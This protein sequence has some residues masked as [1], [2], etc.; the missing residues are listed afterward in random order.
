MH[1]VGFQ[2]NIAQLQ[3]ARNEDFVRN[4]YVSLLG[5]DPRPD[6][7]SRWTGDID[8]GVR[9]FDDFNKYLMRT[10]EYDQQVNYNFKKL[11]IQ[12][13]DE[14]V[15]MDL[16]KP[17]REYGGTQPITEDTIV[18]FLR[19]TDKFID[20]Y[21]PIVTNLWKVLKDTD[22]TDVLLDYYLTNFKMDT[23][24]TVEKLQDD[25]LSNT[26]FV[27]V[28][29]M[30]CPVNDIA[31]V[32]GTGVSVDDYR[33]VLDI[34]KNAKLAAELYLVAKDVTKHPKIKTL[35]Q[36]YPTH[37]NRDVTVV[38]LLR[39]LPSL[40]SSQ[41]VDAVV[42]KEKDAYYKVFETVNNTYKTYLGRGID[43]MFFIKNHLSALDE[44]RIE[45]YTDTIIDTIVRSDE[46]RDTIRTYLATLYALNSREHEIMDKED[47]DQ[48]LCILLVSKVPATDK[49]RIETTLTDYFKQMNAFISSV[50]TLFQE[51]LERALEK[52]E[53]QK[54]KSR[55]RAHVTDMNDIV[56]SLR[57][58]YEYIH[59]IHKLVDSIA[60]DM[61]VEG[62][63]KIYRVVETMLDDPNADKSKI[64][65]CM[66]ARRILSAM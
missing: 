49:T 51:N 10:R 36:L 40:L 35:V 1:Q 31:E 19:T 24:Y 63:G 37:F 59:L 64:A 44:K 13:I 56:A 45:K 6:I 33:K 62:K 61:G 14:N 48:L 34:M 30:Q 26:G 38:E 20:K 32:I 42:K 39:I 57:S 29:G 16:V 25:I 3:M 53:E 9:T 46:Y 12:H 11:Y 22:I 60:A 21:R 54:F 23:T 65:I 55:F 47:M 4:I 50:D 66:N 5:Q 17:M 27:N 8:K 58:S 52:E 28:E 2:K 41:D 15:D 18:R 43:D 7:V